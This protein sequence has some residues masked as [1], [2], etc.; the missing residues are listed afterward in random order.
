MYCK[1]SLDR[2]HYAMMYAPQY[3][4]TQETTSFRMTDIVSVD[5]QVLK[6]TH[7]VKKAITS[8][9]AGQ[10]STASTERRL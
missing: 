7:N 6:L 10:H 2:T 1:K 8:T 9:T 5:I 4:A 3:N